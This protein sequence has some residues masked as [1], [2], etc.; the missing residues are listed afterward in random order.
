MFAVLWAKPKKYE[1]K[2]E[3]VKDLH[4]AFPPG[5]MQGVVRKQIDIFKGPHGEYIAYRQHETPAVH[6]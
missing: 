3:R 5:L 1:N 2:I 4:D 6:L